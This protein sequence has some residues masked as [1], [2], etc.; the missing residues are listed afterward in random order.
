MVVFVTFVDFIFIICLFMKHK[1]KAW[2]WRQIYIPTICKNFPENEENTK[3]GASQGPGEE[4]SGY[5]SPI[6]PL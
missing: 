3:I 1:D 4:Q 6:I 2:F 5:R